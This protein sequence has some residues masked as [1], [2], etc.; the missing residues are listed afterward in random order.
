MSKSTW[1][2]W[3][4]LL[5]L[6]GWLFAP[7]LSGT[8]SV[9]FRDA[10]HY[11]HPLFQYVSSEWR[12]GRVPLWNPYEN[13]GMPLAADPTASVFYPGQLLFLLPG[14]Y[15][16]LYN[17]YI[18]AHVL[19]AAITSWFLARHWNASVLAAG[20]A[21]MTYAFSGPVLFNHSNVVFLVGAAWLP[22]ALLFAD[23]A[24]TAA[25]LRNSAP[26]I[27]ALGLVLALMI[28]GGDP[29]MACNVVLLAGLLCF[30]R[31]QSAN[32]DGVI[33]GSHHFP[34]RR[35]TLARVG[36]A[37]V[38]CGLLAAVQILPSADVGSRSARASFEAPRSLWELA[39]NI[40]AEAGE[41]GPP[42]YSG[43]LGT[44]PGD[45]QGQIYEFSVPPWRAIELI[46]PNISGQEF[47]T[48]HRWPKALGAEGRVWT[49]SLYMGLVCILLAAIT[50]SVRAQ[51]PRH[52]R[53]L[54]WIAL[55]GGIGSLGTYGLGYLARHALEFIGEGD[56]AC[57]DEVGGLYWFLTVLVPGYVM[58]RYP[59]KLLVLVSLGLSQLAAVGFDRLSTG[60]VARLRRAA[61]GM[62]LFT[63]ITEV[64][65]MRWSWRKFSDHV[66]NAGWDDTFGPLDEQLVHFTVLGA[67][68]QT[69]L[70]SAAIWLVTGRMNKPRSLR[71][72]LAALWLLTA[73][74]LAIAQPKLIVFASAKLLSKPPQLLT[75]LQSPAQRTR[76]ARQVNGEPTTF[77]LY[78]SEVRM[79]EVVGWDRDTLL[80]KYALPYHVGIIDAPGNLLPSDQQI[81]WQV[82]RDRGFY[83]EGDSY[84]NYGLDVLGVN[85]VIVDSDETGAAL[86]NGVATQKRSS[87]L[88]RSWIVH[89]VRHLLPLKRP[90]RE[91][92]LAHTREIFS[93]LTPA[94]DWRKAAVVESD[95]FGEQIGDPPA[96]SAQQGDESCKIVVDEPARV[97]IAAQLASP[98]LVVLA[99]SYDP[100]WDL[101]VTTDGVERPAEILRTNRVARGCWLPAGEHRLTYR[102]RPRSVVWGAAIS[103]VSVTALLVCSAI[104]VLRRPMQRAKRTPNTN[105]PET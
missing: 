89:S 42:W 9:A 24:I 10:A 78:A 3:A 68:L 47:P 69:L 43:L 59:A 15:T 61:G 57:G 82:V 67:L 100:G 86:P 101:A 79:S 104:C 72:A 27:V 36:L 75:A 49:P 21:A 64:I 30:L 99:D 48:S 51:A 77:R 102:Y 83:A 96:D 33:Q 31:P 74:D 97:E 32:A 76:A 22:L 58:F 87:A 54:S 91:E 66:M 7:V 34:T 46:W 84:P 73:M 6:L 12:A 56:R 2:V 63:G 88:P 95:T 37:A 11:Y 71:Y 55:L 53:W 85:T 8:M 45:H 35:K 90:T 20:L 16:W 17:V 41:G 44:V 19:L 14:D 29:Q 50:W 93:P 81:F 52:V 62:L 1:F 92:L 39:S 80:P 28:A 25:S 98:G 23:S 70:F 94:V 18:V 40:S 65:A 38:A 103:G 60:G 13:C 26:P 105:Q 5:A 4:G